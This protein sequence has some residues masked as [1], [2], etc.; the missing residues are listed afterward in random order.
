MPDV[1]ADQAD[2]YK[3]CARNEFGKA[4]VTVALNVIEGKMLCAS[5]MFVFS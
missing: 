3:C 5:C 2:T 1:T 4:L